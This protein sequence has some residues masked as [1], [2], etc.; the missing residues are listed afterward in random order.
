M[1]PAHDSSAS[2]N[3]GSSVERT[4]EILGWKP[5]PPDQLEQHLSGYE[6]TGFIA[7]GGM[8]AV[9]RGEQLSLG[10]KVAIK[11]LPPQLRSLDPN[12]AQ[13]FKL[14]ARSMGQLNHP[15]IVSVYDFGEMADGTLYFIMEYI[16]G[17]D[18]AQMVASQGRLSSQHAMSITAHVCDALEY[19]HQ[20]GV[21]HRDI[22]PANIMVGYDG[23]VKVADFGLAKSKLQ[24]NTSSLTISGHVMGTPHFVAPEALTLGVEVDHRADIYAVG[25]M[26]YQMLTGKLPQGMFEM[27]SKV[28]LGLDPRYD[29]IVASAMRD[30]RECRYQRILDMRRALDAILTKPVA[31]VKVDASRPPA[32][33]NTIGRPQR[34]PQAVARPP[35]AEKRKKSSMSWVLAAMMVPGLA[36][37]VMLQRGNTPIQAPAPAS[38]VETPKEP[39]TTI[40]PPASKLTP[41]PAPIPQ[42]P[43]PTPPQP[44]VTSVPATPPAPPPTTVTIRSK[45][46]AFEE[47]IG[48]F[49][50]RVFLPLGI[51]SAADSTAELNRWRD[52]LLAEGREKPETQRGRYRA[53]YYLATTLASTAKERQN[54]QNPAQWEARTNAL[55]PFVTQLITTFRS[56]K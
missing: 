11:I 30:D 49:I 24:A 15:G 25:V 27:P 17:T 12:Y 14:E 38:V 35:H 51:T 16:D 40:D 48:E 18:V 26:L 39:V 9:Y 54:A 1:P 50:P 10:R 4:E 53:A 29:E 28:V 22:K 8:G 55:R 21:V 44:K 34:P 33:L 7:R 3:A 46:E 47:Q 6:V 32:A 20:N 2:P 31:K 36:L 56:T 5:L 43:A 13:R 52:E 37:W 19:A 45:L 41:P 23:R 42:P